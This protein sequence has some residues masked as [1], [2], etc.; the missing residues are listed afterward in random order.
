MYRKVLDPD[1]GVW[2][3]RRYDL[4]LYYQ[5]EDGQIHAYQPGQDTSRD[6]AFPA[7]AKKHGL[8]L[9]TRADRRTLHREERARYKRIK[10]RRSEGG[11]VST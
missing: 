5:A 2:G 1:S 4:S 6:K 9:L 10:A 11:V 7:I 3:W 8:K